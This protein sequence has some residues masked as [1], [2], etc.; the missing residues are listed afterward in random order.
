MTVTLW[1]RKKDHY[2]KSYKYKYE[3]NW[4]E[5]LLFCYQKAKRKKLD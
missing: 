3:F 2:E 1:E 4:I 5:L